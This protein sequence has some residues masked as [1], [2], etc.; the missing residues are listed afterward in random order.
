M[1]EN[2]NAASV[3]L[4]KNQA[5]ASHLFD[6]IRLKVFLRGKEIHQEVCEEREIFQGSLL[7]SR[8]V[9]HGPYRTLPPMGKAS[10]EEID[11]L[12]DK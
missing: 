6:A 11:P 7:D 4:L 2:K 10:S 5:Q 12:D 8:F 1:F 9:H 3:R